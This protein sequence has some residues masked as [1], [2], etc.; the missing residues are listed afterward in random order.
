MIENFYNTL[1]NCYARKQIAKFGNGGCISDL[2][3]PSMIFS[4]CYNLAKT[5]LL[6]RIKATNSSVNIGLPLGTHLLIA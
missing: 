1:P 5:I 6:E 4:R 3:L 2:Q